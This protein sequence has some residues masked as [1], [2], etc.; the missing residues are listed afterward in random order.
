MAV[1]LDHP[2]TTSRPIDDSF[3]TVTDLD[4][5]VPASRAGA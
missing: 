5:V 4:R 3:A 1:E 2:F